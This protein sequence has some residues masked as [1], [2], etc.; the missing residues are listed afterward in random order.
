MLVYE[1]DTEDDDLRIVDERDIGE[2]NAGERASVCRV[3][4]LSKLEE[5]GIDIEIVIWYSVRF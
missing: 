5:N 2:L 3:R 1:S 4:F